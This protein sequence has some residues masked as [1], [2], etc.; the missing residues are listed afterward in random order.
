MSFH[1]TQCVIEI[2][3][4]VV[5]VEVEYEQD[6]S[7]FHL[8]SALAQEIIPPVQDED[9][10]LE[11]KAFSEDTATARFEKDLFEGEFDYSVDELSLYKESRY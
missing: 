1:K 7:S 3:Q 10:A 2:D 11:F 9:E 8:L 6:G 4:H 5:T